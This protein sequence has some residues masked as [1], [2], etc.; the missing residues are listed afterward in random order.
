MS[1]DGNVKRVLS[2]KLGH[3][4][5]NKMAPEELDVVFSLCFFLV[6]GNPD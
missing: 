3:T 6:P 5:T 4:D 2:A 1:A